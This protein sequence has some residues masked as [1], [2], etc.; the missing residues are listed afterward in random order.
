M[1]SQVR[2]IAP[3]C[4]AFMAP[5]EP[6]SKRSRRHLTSQHLHTRA[7]RSLYLASCPGAVQESVRRVSDLASTGRETGF[8]SCIWITRL[9]YCASLD[10]REPCLLRLAHAQD[11]AFSA[12]GRFRTGVEVGRCVLL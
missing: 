2:M 11:Q 6:K 1:K 7:F 4:C 3:D 10:R 12:P 8:H 9:R 5:S